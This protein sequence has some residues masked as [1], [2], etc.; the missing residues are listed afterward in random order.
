M[1]G[2]EAALAEARR[3]HE[4]NSSEIDKDR[5]EIEHRA[6]A[7]E[8]CGQKVKDRLEEALRKASRF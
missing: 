6:E 3:E 7:E 1:K 2:A 5:A 4:E 8:E